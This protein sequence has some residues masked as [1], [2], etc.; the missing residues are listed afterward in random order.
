MDV[1]NTLTVNN[2]NFVV[3]NTTDYSLDQ[4]LDSSYG[5]ELYYRAKR[6][7]AQS[8]WLDLLKTNGFDGPTLLRGGVYQS[9]NRLTELDFHPFM[10]RPFV[11]YWTLDDDWYGLMFDGREFLLQGNDGQP[12]LPGLL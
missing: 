5:F 6:G 4:Y 2:A 1:F 12:F 7:I 3:T 10:V 8:R 11:L 9:E